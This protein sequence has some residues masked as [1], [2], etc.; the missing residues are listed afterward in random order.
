MWGLAVVVIALYM[1][2]SYFTPDV[3]LYR[4]RTFTRMWMFLPPR[5]VLTN[6]IRDVDARLTSLMRFK[7][8]TDVN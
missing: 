5:S 8:L 2:G 6:G 4:G 3:V 7:T 1:L